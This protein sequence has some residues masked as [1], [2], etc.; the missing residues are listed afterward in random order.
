MPQVRALA[1][2]WLLVAATAAVGTACYPE[3][4]VVEGPA[5]PGLIKLEI[6]PANVALVVQPAQPAVQI[7]AALGTFGDRRTLDVS[8]KVKWDITVPALGLFHGNRFTSTL[9]RGG[10]ATV[11]AT[12]HPYDATAELLLTYRAGLVRTDAPADSAA[13]FAAASE[14]ASRAPRMI[15]PANGATLRGTQAQEFRWSPA[16]GTDLYELA[17]TNETTDL[18]IYS[19]S[20]SVTPTAEEWSILSA[21]NAGG[22]V[23]VTV[24][25]MSSTSPTT[26]GTAPRIDVVFER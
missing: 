7:F 25:G 13:L 18:R 21:T 22:G 17:F 6:A 12:A 20:S 14:S 8:G 3:E 2:G 16:P 24:R 23:A 9:I 4:E 5:I 26:A 15:A 1:T 11:R 10:K 19:R